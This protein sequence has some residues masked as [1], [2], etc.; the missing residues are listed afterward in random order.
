MPFPTITAAEIIKRGQLQISQFPE[1]GGTTNGFQAIVDIEKD[2]ASAELAL[3]YPSLVDNTDA[4]ITLVIRT[5]IMYR[6]LGHLWQQIKSTFD[7]YDAARLPPEY[8]DSD[9]AA[10]NR[11][12]YL[13][14]ARE[15]LAILDG[16]I[17]D[18]NP[19]TTEDIW[20]PQYLPAVATSDSYELKN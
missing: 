13:A 12:W 1:S 17:P 6:A 20:K 8:V 18:M 19:D 9:Q 2:L 11:D 5:Y 4:N 14:G 15:Q 3:A 10:A 7:G 16:V